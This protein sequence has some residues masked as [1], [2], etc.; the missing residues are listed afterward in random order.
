MGL[1]VSTDDKGVMVFANEKQTAKGDKF[2]LY[3]IGVSSKDQSGKY[4]NGYLSCRFKKGVTVANKTKIKINNAFFVATKSGDK[5]Y[6]SLMITDFVDLDGN[7]A[8]NGEEW[9]NIA[10]I[11]ENELP[12]AD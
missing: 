8:S 3:S 5:T 12:F 1:T 11:A 10:D 7:S 2:T 6:T 4:V 9:A